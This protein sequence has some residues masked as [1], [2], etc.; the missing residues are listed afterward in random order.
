MSDRP[1]RFEIPA[2]V[3]PA[4]RERMI[5]GL[6]IVGAQN[7]EVRAIA[8]RLYGQ[9][10]Q[11]L[12]RA[13]TAVELLQW[14]TDRVHDLVDYIPDPPTQEIFDTVEFSLFSRTGKS[15]SPITGDLKGSGDC[16]ELA[17][18]LVA[19]GRILGLNVRPRWWDQPGASL[20]HVSAEACDGGS[21]PS[22]FA[23]WPS[24]RAGCI[25]VETTVPGAIVGETPY[26]A[27][28]RTGSMVGDRVFGT[29]DFQVLSFS[30]MEALR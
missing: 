25:P 9:L 10:A 22:D 26:Q 11:N 2:T 6:A 4:A 21:L 3:P 1:Q 17:K 27:L 8:E 30:P 24:T 15:V 13:P 20:N 29:N 5:Y 14:L 7:P 23:S 18:V 28:A 19:F 16:E 12:G